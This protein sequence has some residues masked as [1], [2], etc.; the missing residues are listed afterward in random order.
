MYLLYPCICNSD[1]MHVSLSHIQFSY[2]LL[3]GQTACC[4]C[5]LRELN[6]LLACTYL[7][8]LCTACSFLRWSFVSSALSSQGP[9]QT[10]DGATFFL[11][12]LSWLIS[13]YLACHMIITCCNCHL[14]LECHLNLWLGR[15][16]PKCSCQVPGFQ[17]SACPG[18]PAIRMMAPRLQQRFCSYIGHVQAIILS[19]SCARGEGCWWIL[20]LVM[21]GIDFQVIQIELQRVYLEQSSMQ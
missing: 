16:L 4:A 5:S 11:S 6:I 13:A 14:S 7:G 2:L 20:W 10:C 17:Y 9:N 12:N 21:I 19:C 8:S 18:W 1:H 15:H 3:L